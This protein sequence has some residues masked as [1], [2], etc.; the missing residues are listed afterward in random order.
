MYYYYDSDDGECKTIVAY[1]CG[2]AQ[3]RNQFR[4]LM[5]CLNA[6]NPSSK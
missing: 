2:D 6:C 1:Q 4:N 5:T 3:N